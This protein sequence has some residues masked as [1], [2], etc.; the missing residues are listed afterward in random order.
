M[1]WEAHEVEV[2][3]HSEMSAHASQ[4]RLTSIPQEHAKVRPSYGQHNPPR[5][6]RLVQGEGD[7]D[8]ARQDRE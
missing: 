4:P 6:M 2:T 7:Y 8:R 5:I 1:D 3:W